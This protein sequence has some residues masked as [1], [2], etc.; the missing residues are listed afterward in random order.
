[1]IQVFYMAWRYLNYHKLKTVVLILSVSLIIFIPLGL[2]SL[3]NSGSKNMIQ[4]A[5]DTPLLIGAKGSPTELNLSALY[6]K[7][8]QL[9]PIPY[10]EVNKINKTHLAEAIPLHLK[11]NV[12][13]QPIVGTNTVYFKFRDLTFNAGRPMAILGECV[14]GAKASAILNAKVGD[15]ILS[16]PAGAFDIAGSFPL[17]M[18]VVGVLNQVNTPDDQ[19]VFVDIKTTWVIAGIAHGHQELNTKI[20]DSLII[21]KTETNVVA[22]SAV[23]S[24]TEITKE[25]IDSFHFHGNQKE[26][27][28][29][30]IIAVPKDKKS[31]LMLRGRY[32]NEVGNVQMIAPIHIITELLKTVFSIRNLLILAAITIGLATLAICTLV[33]IL[34]AQLRAS[35]LNTMK[36]IGAARGFIFQ[37]LTIEIVLILGISTLLAW[38]YTLLLNHFGQSLIDNFLT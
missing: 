25:N 21:S 17:K 9:P 14:L 16:S 35:E 23:L 8:A 5:Q 13:N 33:F 15:F 26:F 31:G 32:E 22:N 20:A 6:F 27:P 2:N 4:R 11:Y 36:R 28:I 38:G 37:L 29:D 12:K 24:Y 30:A 34:S 10:H 3:T 18:K 7:T 19:A 1:M